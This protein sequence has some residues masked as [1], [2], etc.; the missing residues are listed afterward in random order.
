[1][2]TENAKINDAS[3]GIGGYQDAQ[4]GLNL[5]FKMKSGSIRN[6][7]IGM[8]NPSNTAVVKQPLKETRKISF[9]ILKEISKILKEANVSNL[10]ELKNKKVVLQIEKLQPNLEL[11]SITSFIFI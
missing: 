10:E 8:W 4:I 7:F 11:E 5:E 3:F 6:K 2:Y 9:D 1:M